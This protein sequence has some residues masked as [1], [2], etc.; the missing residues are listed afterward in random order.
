[1]NQAGLELPDTQ[2]LALAEL[3]GGAPGQAVALLSGGGLAIYAEIIDLLRGAPRISRPAI[4]ALAEKCAG[5]EAAEHYDMVVR[6]ISVALARMARQGAGGGQMARAAAAEAEVAARLSANPRQALI[7]AD[8]L[9]ELT[10][11]IAHARAVNLDPGQVILDTF[12][13]ID[14]AAGQASLRSA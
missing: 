14:A 13:R 6:L 1:V 3:S 11:R 10:D 12:L 5:R 9:Q 8:L 4:L 2:A 7:W